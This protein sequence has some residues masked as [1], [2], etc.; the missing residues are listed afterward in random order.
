MQLIPEQISYLRK[1]EQELKQSLAGYSDYFTARDRS[2]IEHSIGFFIGD[3]LIDNQYKMTKNSLDQVVDLL[4]NSDY[5]VKR[6][7]ETIQIG[8]KFIIA[9]DNMQETNTLLLTD[10]IYGFAPNRSFVSINSPI[11]QSVLGAKEGDSISYSLPGQLSNKKITGTIEKIVTNQDEYLHFIRERKLYTR[12]SKQA[13]REL[14]ELLSSTNPLSQIEYSARQEI[15]PSQKHLLI[16]E[17][18]HLTK[19][20]TTPSEIMRLNN[21]RKALQT[22]KSATAPTDGTIG[23][24]ST[25]E[26]LLTDGVST[27]IKTKEFINNAVSTELEDEYIERISPLGTKLFGLKTND[28]FSFRKNNQTYHGTVLSVANTLSKDDSKE[29]I[30]KIKK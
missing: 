1:K 30:Q 2:S 9:F 16:I 8:T 25:I 14:H 18:N 12:S 3:P 29:N 11:G 17:A 24:G 23:V 7:T 4:T 10:A 6:N 26:I 19:T 28:T 20:A 5:V 27:D 22:A 13:R 15:T 21:I